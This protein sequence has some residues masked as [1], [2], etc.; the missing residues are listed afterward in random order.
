[1]D[2]G[3]PAVLASSAVTGLVSGVVTVAGLR[4][5]VQWL[6]QTVEQL[7]QAVATL[8]SD[9]QAMTRRIER[10]DAAARRAHEKA[11]GVQ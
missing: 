11:E 5:H 3:V 2:L 9:H 10:A 8:Q 7:Q 4:V 1:M 6:K